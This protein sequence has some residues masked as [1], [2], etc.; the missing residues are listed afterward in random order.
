M[1]VDAPDPTFVSHRF[2]R[3]WRPAGLLRMT[4]PRCHENYDDQNP[5]G[6]GSV[7]RPGEARGTL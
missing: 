4:E 2:G 6:D 1:L 5:H 3:V 7:Q